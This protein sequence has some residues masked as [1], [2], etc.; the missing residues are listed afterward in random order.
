VHKVRRSENAA[1]LDRGGHKR[2]TS[3]QG[4]VSKIFCGAKTL[5]AG[6]NPGALMG[7]VMLRPFVIGC[8][9]GARACDVVDV[10]I[11]E[12]AQTPWAVL[13]THA[14]ELYPPGGDVRFDC[15]VRVD[16]ARSAFEPSGDCRSTLGIAASYG[17]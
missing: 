4:S 2:P 8:R 16:V 9:S 15:E 17:A 1:G 10:E 3:S 5:I 7:A 11:R 12:L 13:D 6:D 14:A